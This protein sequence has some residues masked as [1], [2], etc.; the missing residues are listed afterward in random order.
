MGIQ[1][2]GQTDTI[3]ATDGSL[4]LGGTVTVNVTGDATGLSGTPNIN[5]GV[6]TAASAVISGNL[7]VDGTTTTLDTLLTEVDKL[8]VGANNTTVGVAITQSGTGDILRLYD[9][10][11]QVVTVKDGG[12]FGIGVSPDTKLTIKGS[13]NSEMLR[14]YG[15]SGGNVRG[16]KISTYQVAGS[17]D[18]A[19]VD[20]NAQQAAVGQLRFSTL[21]TPR[22]L[23]DQ[24][25]R[26]GIGTDDPAV[27]L[28]V[29]NT[30]PTFRVTGNSATNPTITLSSAT[31]TAWSQTVSGTDSS[32]SISRDGTERLRINSSGKVGIN[33]DDPKQFLHVAGRTTFD[34]RGDY[35]GAW[36]DGDTD[37]TSSFNVGAWYN[38]GGRLRDSGN[39]VVVETMNTAHNLQLQPNGGDV[40]IGHDS[41]SCKLA[42]K[43]T[44]TH[45]AY[46]S[47]TP[48]V[49]DCM[50]A[51]YNNPSSEAINNH[52][53]IQFGVNGGTYNRV[54]SISAVAES[55]SSRN[56][57]LTFC[58]DDA[59]NRTEKLRIYS[60]GRLRHIGGAAANSGNL[61][62]GEYHRI[63]TSTSVNPSSS[64]TFIFSGLV[65]GWM[66][67]RGGGYSN[68]GQSQFACAYQ[69][70]GYMTATSTYDIVTI[71][72]WTNGATISTT[73]N[74]S[75]YRVTITN[76]SAT[77]A[78]VSNF[79]VESSSYLLKVA[80]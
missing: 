69:L 47:Q 29:R 43:D 26:V 20:F 24:L 37:G 45:T 21:S 56:T 13:D 12:D 78:L 57:S 50:L 62:N 40:G 3:S 42:I 77:Y 34:V 18:N 2:N 46:A 14:M 80:T 60:D 67:I 63:C 11:S 73:K 53:T 27:N 30:S 39:N 22:M 25:G 6:L 71:Q 52:A 23:I 58:T 5:V 51:L 68:A 16:L 15:S 35:Y 65:S 33:T 31:I 61:G 19:G 48:N 64:V 76:N 75:D 70:G 49:V 59:N 7:Q 44:A 66:T 41:P 54:C 10:A 9:G 72:Q 17:V 55:A 1:I 79:T 8:E 28:E 4:N 36:I 74:A 32:F 38:I